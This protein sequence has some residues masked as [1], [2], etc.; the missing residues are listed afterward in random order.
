MLGRGLLKD[1]PNPE[2]I[3]CPGADVINRIAAQKMPLAEAEKWLD[4]L[5]SC[6]PCYADFKRLQE[7]HDSRRRR[8]LLA[9][10]AGIF[11]A[12]AATG[13]ALL[14]QRDG[15][16]TAQTAVLDLRDRSP[17]RGAEGNPAEPPPEMSRRVSHLKIYLPLGSSD[18]EYAI[19]I[20]AVDEHKTVF[21][22]KGLAS[23]QQGIT[24]LALDIDLRAAS[25]G[26]YVLQIR[27]V[28]SEWTSYPLQLK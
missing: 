13:W 1:F 26:L 8:V 5:G 14:H 3:G 27:E 17:A 16:L 2:R 7:A 15:N 28:G 23:N 20:S 10:A 11:L 21:A 4:H 6:S 19:R 25:P 9:T 18:G 24:L 22:A 12:L